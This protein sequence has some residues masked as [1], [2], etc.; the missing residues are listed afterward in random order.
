MKKPNTGGSLA[1]VGRIEGVLCE[2]GIQRGTLETPATMNT[3]R[4]V[5]SEKDP[6]ENF[7]CRV[8]N[9]KLCELNE[10]YSVFRRSP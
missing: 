7:V 3:E 10:A 5:L 1:S 8:L 2:K 9:W 4:T 6:P